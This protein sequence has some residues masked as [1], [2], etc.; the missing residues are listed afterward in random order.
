MGMFALRSILG[1]QLMLSYEATVA[2]IPMVVDAICPMAGRAYAPTLASARIADA[3]IEAL[4]VFLM[5]SPP[6]GK[7]GFRLKILHSHLHRCS[8]S[9]VFLRKYQVL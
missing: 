8:F 5:I 7:V 9:L 6:W 3:N 1:L 4:T 2:E